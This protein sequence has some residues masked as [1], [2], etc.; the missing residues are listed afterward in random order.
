M[1]RKILI[2]NRGEIALRVI[3]TC[4]EMGIESVAVYSD[5]DKD[6]L[7]VKCADEAVNIGPAL[8]RK[9]YLNIDAIIDAARKVGAEAIHPGYGFL[10][11]DARFSE[12][13]QNKGVVFIGPSS[14]SQ[15]LVGDKIECRKIAEKVGVPLSP[16][17]DGAVSS[18]EAA[19]H[20]AKGL[21]YPLIIKACG[22][23]GGKGMRIANNEEELPSFIKLCK[24][25]A[26]A[27]FGNPDVFIEK[28][29]VEAR[30]IEIQFLG[31][32]LGN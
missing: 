3:R 16:G 25:E 4:K 6:S 18:E 26:S 9:S 5:A 8:A 23:G 27:S 29:I 31:D 30:H 12:Q 15:K 17:S 10:A 11:E 19:I 24:G 32:G 7:H 22:G 28:Y 2:A 13:C 20:V 14:E 1:Y 21:G